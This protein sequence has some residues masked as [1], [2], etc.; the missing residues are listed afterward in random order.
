MDVKKSQS[1]CDNNLTY[2]IK[3]FIYVSCFRLFDSDTCINR[4][5]CPIAWFQ[6]KVHT[7]C[8]KF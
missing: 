2:Y 6:I 4:S 8:W 1:K 7:Y 3:W 5:V